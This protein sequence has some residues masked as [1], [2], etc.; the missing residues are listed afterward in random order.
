[1]LFYQWRYIFYSNKGYSRSYSK[2]KETNAERRVVRR[3]NMAL[4]GCKKCIHIT[5][6]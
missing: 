1:M 2:S 5:N 3:K 6:K 4:R